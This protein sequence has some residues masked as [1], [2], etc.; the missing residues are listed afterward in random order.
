MVS[1]VQVTQLGESRPWSN[2]AP[3]LP[4]TCCVMWGLALTLS[5]PTFLHL[6]KK[7][8]TGAFSTG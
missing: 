2:V 1:F 4:L 8:W 7:A 3:A 5:G 6:D